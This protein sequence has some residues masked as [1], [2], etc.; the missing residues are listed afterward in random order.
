MGTRKGKLPVRTSLVR[1]G[2][3]RSHV[4]WTVYYSAPHFITRTYAIARLLIHRSHVYPI[5]SF[6][7][8]L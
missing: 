3:R 4:M 5:F 7:W 8:T 1:L 2:S 6:R